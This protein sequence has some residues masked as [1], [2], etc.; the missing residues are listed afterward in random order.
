[1]LGWLFNS[2][3]R[4]IDRVLA[5]TG[6]EE[7]DVLYAGT[8]DNET[9]RNTV[10]ELDSRGIDVTDLRP[11]MVEEEDGELFVDDVHASELED[12]VVFYREA[13]F[14]DGVGREAEKAWQMDRLEQEYGIEFVNSPRGAA[15]CSDKE[16]TKDFMER[17]IDDFDRRD[18]V[19][20]ADDRF[21]DGEPVD[22]EWTEF[23][24]TYWE[25]EEERLD[26]GFLRVPETYESCERARKELDE[27]D[28][29]VKK[30]REGSLGE[31]IEFLEL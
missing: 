7:A 3:S 18:L 22:E 14:E 27:D 30:P 12:T 19:E 26:A 5:S 2:R 21:E 13:S 25:D 1:M 20:F 11:E 29:L 31:G 9:R 16:V 10:E 8:W 23:L 17:A 15:V 6:V 28:K 4:R 24:E